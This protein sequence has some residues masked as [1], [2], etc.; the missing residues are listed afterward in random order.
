MVMQNLPGGGGDKRII[1][2][3]SKVANG[4]L[5]VL[6]LRSEQSCIGECSN[7]SASKKCHICA[8]TRFVEI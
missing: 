4:L 8:N 3:F 6:F 5:T 2:V 7:K 1:M